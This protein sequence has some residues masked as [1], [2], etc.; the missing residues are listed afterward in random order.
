[1]T[2]AR[3]PNMLVRIT[4]S[5]RMGCSHCMIEATPN[6]K[7]MS[8]DVFA[9]A[10]AFIKKHNFPIIMLTGGEPTDH[11]DFFRLAETV[12]DSGLYPLI[13]S[14]G[15][16]LEDI[17]KRDKILSLGITI[18]ITSDPR[19]YPK[20]IEKF[21]HPLLNY[22]HEIRAITPLGRAKTNHLPSARQ[23]PLCFNLR[24]LV[25]SFRNFNQAIV[26]LR[27]SEKMCTPSIN[28]DG[29]I[30]AGESSLCCPIGTLDS[31]DD[32]LTKNILSMQCNKCGLED[33][34]SPLHKRAIGL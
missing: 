19:F 23:S 18:Q 8:T 31:S 7:H 25:R 21:N 6:G 22:E 2:L 32:E 12:K 9:K 15:M 16:F 33:N 4:N 27:L 26:Y 24:S 28:V 5:C 34:L 20:K 1:M 3:K 17:A 14:N 11:P 30:V 13:L 10:I 29:T